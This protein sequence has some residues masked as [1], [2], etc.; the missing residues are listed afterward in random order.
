MHIACCLHIREDVLLKLWDWLQWI[1]HILVL[2]NVANDLCS[3]AALG[4]VDEV[5]L[6]NDSWNTILNESKVSQIDT[7]CYVSIDQDGRT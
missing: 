3:L 4:E 2:L 1:W 5:G 7:C 6:L